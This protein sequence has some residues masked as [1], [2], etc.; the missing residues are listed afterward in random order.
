VWQQKQKLQPADLQRRHGFGCSVAIQ[1]QVAVVGTSDAGSAYIFQLNQGTWQQKQKLYSP[2]VQP[3]DGFGYTVAL[4]E[5][6]IITGAHNADAQGRAYAGS[7][8]I[9]FANEM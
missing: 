8:Y 9:A 6:V 3:K 2:E 1:G 7:A 5:G 4:S